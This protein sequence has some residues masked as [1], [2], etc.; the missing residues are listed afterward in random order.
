MCEAILQFFVGL[1]YI[2]LKFNI[3]L[4]LK[5]E[6]KL[7]L[8]IWLWLNIEYFFTYPIERKE[9]KLFYSANVQTCKKKLHWVYNIVIRKLLVLIC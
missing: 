8:V 9:K 1:T 6:D 3:R 7:F 4:F 2:F 5:V